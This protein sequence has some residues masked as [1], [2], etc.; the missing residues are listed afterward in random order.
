MNPIYPVYVISKGRHKSCLT[1]RELNLMKVPFFLVVEPQ[2]EIKYRNS[3]PNNNILI[4]PFSNLGKGSIPVRNFVWEHSIKN[5]H[6]KHWVLDDNIEGFHRLNRNMKPK[7]LD[8]TIFR[9]CEDFT[10]RYLNI[11]ISGMNYYSFCKA[12]DKIPPFYLN[13]RVYSCILI[14]NNLDIRWR[15]LFNEDTDLCLRVLKKGLCTVLFNAFLIGKVTTMRMNG[16]NKSIYKK[17]NNRLQFAQSLK[18]QHPEIVEVVWRFNRWH[19]S[20]NYAPFKKNKLIR[21]KDIPIKKGVNN[22][23]MKLIELS[24]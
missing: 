6:K 1:A 9:C 10:N 7:V 2:E 8:G 5:G 4:T 12:S 13:T 17:T 21:N 23:G 14:D 11:G 18:N 19:H 16:G 24:N 15:G 20:V 3:Y 22:Y